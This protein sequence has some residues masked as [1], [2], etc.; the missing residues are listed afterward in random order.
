MTPAEVKTI[1]DALEYI[2]KR[3]GNITKVHEGPHGPHCT[4]WL[5]QTEGV[6]FL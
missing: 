1:V 3:Y 4:G 2:F 5:N 6:D